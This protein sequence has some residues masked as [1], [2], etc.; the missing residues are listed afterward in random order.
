MPKFPIFR[1]PLVGVIGTIGLFAGFTPQMDPIAMQ[2]SQAGDVS[3]SSSAK[4]TVKSS[5]S[6]SSTGSS[7]GGCRSETR[8]SA[9]VT[10]VIDG[11]TKT[12]RQ[13][14]ADHS[15]E[16]GGRSDSEAKAVI[17]D[18]EPEDGEAGQ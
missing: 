8:S 6:A 17:D 18:S 4:A 2:P 7:T 1:W 3:A 14:D 15:D 16:C 10:T 13:E 11:E 9:E 5:S 12:V